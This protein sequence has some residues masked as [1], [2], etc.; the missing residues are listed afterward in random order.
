MG[1]ISSCPTTVDEAIAGV[2]RMLYACRLHMNGER[3]FGSRCGMKSEA[4]APP[5]NF[6]EE[7][8]GRVDHEIF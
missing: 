4:A 5:I 8:D 7:T 6:K 2:I 1:G 3:D